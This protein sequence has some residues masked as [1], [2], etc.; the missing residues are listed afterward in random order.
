[1]GQ[2]KGQNREKQNG[3]KTKNS[4]ITS[5]HH[6]KQKSMKPIH[7]KEI[8]SALIN[9]CREGFVRDPSFHWSSLV[10]RSAGQN[11]PV[12][13]THPYS[14]HRDWLS[15]GLSDWSGLFT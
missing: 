15:S 7:H 5:Q 1:M 14:Y 10:K 11:L 3:T 12:I 2:K 9:T 4:K 13:H 8:D 6:G